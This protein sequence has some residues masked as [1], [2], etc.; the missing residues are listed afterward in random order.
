MC[1]VQLHWVIYLHTLI[2]IIFGTF[3][4]PQ[5]LHFKLFNFLKINYVDDNTEKKV[6]DRFLKISRTCLLTLIYSETTDRSI[7]F[8]KEKKRIR[9]K[10]GKKCLS[11]KWN[12]L[13]GRINL[14]SLIGNLKS[15]RFRTLTRVILVCN[16]IPNTVLVWILI[17]ACQEILSVFPSF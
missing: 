10:F 11:L 8:L 15:R 9:F 5:I 6:N 3:S 4:F 1:D 17:P 12:Q 13:V 14:I 16:K 2:F 7:H